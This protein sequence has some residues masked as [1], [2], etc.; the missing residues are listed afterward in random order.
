MKYAHIINYFNSQPWAIL[1]DKLHAI[2][3]LI[4]LRAAGLTLTDNEILARIG[5]DGPDAAAGRQELLTPTSVAVLPIVGTISH[6][7]GL[8]RR[9]S[10]G[11]TVEGFREDFKAALNNPDISAIV[12]DIDSPGGS[13]SGIEE[14]A[15]EIYEGRKTKRII[16]SVNSLAASAAYWLASAA[17]E[18]AVTP[19]GH[20]GSIGVLGVHMDFSEQAKKNGVAVTVVSSGKY[21][22][23]ASEFTPLT[24]EARQ[25]LQAIVDDRYD[26]FVRAVARARGTS[27][28]NVRDGY[29]EG[30]LVPAKDALSMG[31]ID[32]VETTD[33]VLSRVSGRAK[34]ARKIAEAASWNFESFVGEDGLETAVAGVTAEEMAAQDREG[35]KAQTL[36]APKK[37]WESLDA[38]RNWA[39]E[40][41][42]R[43]DKV[44][45]TANAWRFRQRDP[46]DF[47]QLRTIC[48]NP[49][50][51]TPATMEACKMLM[52]GGR[53]KEGVAA[54][55]HDPEA[56][57]V[58]EF[59]FDAVVPGNVSEEIAPDGTTWDAPALK[60]FTSKQW[61]ELTSDERRKIAMHAAWAKAMPPEKFSD[62]K[63][64][65]HRPSDGAIVPN[66]VRNALA[67]L[68]QTQGLGEDRSRVEAHLR[69]HMD[70]IQKRR[71]AARAN[72]DLDAD[73]VMLELMEL[74]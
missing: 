42:Y 41:G 15:D 16:A 63:L 58:D 36:I 12:L 62:I 47:R 28:R 1:P 24:D 53:L 14:M 65:H 38:A 37:K 10:G 64:F 26:A 40:H 68:N 71:E 51:E 29:G 7:M 30:R 18:I 70:A 66:G 45:D 49:G 52:V 6:R 56:K 43:V 32:S 5:Q 33:Q 23:E 50:R 69:R 8:L 44:D 74:G 21:K 55:F 72:P 9:A 73:R 57:G 59:L 48:I 60:D 13:T 2:I 46:N 4:E 11:M 20:V 17:H 67:R 54:V 19:S 35:F 25:H 39:K 31:M 34:R 22:S 61:P 3:S 27:Q